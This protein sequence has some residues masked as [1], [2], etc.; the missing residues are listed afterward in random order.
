MEE[1]IFQVD[2]HSPEQTMEQGLRL[3]ELLTPGD[4]VCLHGDLG[5]GKT[6]FTKGLAGYFGV[7]S[8]HV[9]S[10]TYALVQEYQ[11]TDVTIFHIDAYRLNSVDEALGIGL[12]EILNGDGICVVEWPERISGL[13]PELLWKVE[14]IHKGD[15]KRHIEAFKVS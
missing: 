12:D 6:H 3:A 13:L 7:R 2:T 4:V 15:H 14:I 8:E 10:P 5:A 9:S 11:G 1:L